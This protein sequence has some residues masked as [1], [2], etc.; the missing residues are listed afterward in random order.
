[1]VSKTPLA[2]ALAQHM[3]SAF[4]WAI[5]A[6]TLDLG[7][8]TLIVHQRAFSSDSAPL[9]ALQLE[10]QALM[11]LANA[12]QQTGLGS[13]GEAY[14]CIVPPLSYGKKLPIDP[15][16]G[17][18]RRETAD[19]ELRGQWEKIV[20]LYIELFRIFQKFPTE[21][22]GFHKATAILIFILESVSNRLEQQKK[23]QRHD[24]VDR[25]KQ[26]Q[27]T[28]LSE[29]EL[30]GQILRHFGILY[31]TQKRLFL[32][33]IWS[34]ATLGEIEHGGDDE[35][36]N[37][38][39]QPWIFSEILN[40][41][42]A[43]TIRSKFACS[44]DI[45]GWSA[46]HY[47]AVYKEER[48]IL[49][50]IEDGADPNSIAI[51]GRTP[52][53]YAIECMKEGSG[54][55][56]GDRRDDPITGSSGG[57]WNRE[58]AI[59]ALLQC[60]ADVNMQGRDG[61]GPLHCAAKGGNVR[62]AGLL[63]DAGANTEMYDGSRKTPMH[64]AARAGYIRFVDA[65]RCKGASVMSRDDSGRNALHLASMSG[66]ESTVDLLLQRGGVDVF[67]SDRDHRTALHLAAAAGH[68][69]V[70]LILLEA[71]T[72]T[73]VEERNRRTRPADERKAGTCIDI[74]DRQRRTVLH[75]A[76]GNGFQDT[77][78]LLLEKGA[79]VTT[80]DVSGRTALHCPA[81]P[82]AERTARLLLENAAGAGATNADEG[83]ALHL[84]AEDSNSIGDASEMAGN[85]YDLEDYGTVAQLLLGKGASI[86][87][88]DTEGRT[89][90]HI[91]EENGNLAV[92]RKL[93]GH[94][95]GLVTQS[96]EVRTALGSVAG[97]G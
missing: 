35:A 42:S 46:L 69:G 77:V 5:S 47:A 81:E 55:N 87:A 63:L 13:S 94:G 53:H 85:L 92:V 83:T 96:H 40:R 57:A 84:V 74:P 15:V 62:V 91:A 66:S 33:G 16:I 70:V 1:M 9:D 89:P 50:L 39:G 19:H 37:F 2:S 26:L 72:S 34:Q 58:A 7:T 10:N 20:P 68:T 64:L 95:A 4:M 49:E 60:G 44:T 36:H 41:N 3:F 28:L 22:P 8:E 30:H 25:W 48:V 79:S 29:L 75:D 27:K 31:R 11:E 67:V 51:A 80:T 71:M 78:R 21:N 59:T 97:G 73:E 90:L 17:F 93:R 38:F 54:G 56:L 32:S 88:I 24:D 45:I 18:V 76:A 12:V 86:D 23:E 6:E 82:E 14:M 52:L 65:L 61:K 43:S